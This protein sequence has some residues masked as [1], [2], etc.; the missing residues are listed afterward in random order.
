MLFRLY[1]K[2]MGLA[3]ESLHSEADNHEG[4]EAE[5]SSTNP[6]VV[7]GSELVDLGADTDPEILV[8]VDSLKELLK[9]LPKEN[10][11]TLR[12]IIRHLRRSVTRPVLLKRHKHQTLLNLFHRVN[13]LD[14]D[15]PFVFPTTGSQSW[16]KITR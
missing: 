7:R 1:N 8:L 14:P 16:R 10:I 2:L 12:Y 9:E 15:P 6:A 4:E 11:A 13:R 3:K 5:P